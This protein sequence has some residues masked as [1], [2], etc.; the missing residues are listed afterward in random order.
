MVVIVSPFEAWGIEAADG[1]SPYGVWQAKD[2][3]V[4]AN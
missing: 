3:I 2:T 4:P 1:R